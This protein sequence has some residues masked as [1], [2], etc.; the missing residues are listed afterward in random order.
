M[1]DA[2]ERWDAKYRD[3]KW[4][5]LPPCDPFVLAALAEC[6]DG[7]GRRALDAAAGTGRHALELASRGWRTDAWDLSS[8]GLSRLAGFAEANGLGVATR[9]FDLTHALPDDTFD[10]V[11][12]VN[13]LDRELLPRLGR[14][15]SPGG[16]LVFTTFTTD[17][18]S[19]PSERHCLAGGEL[20]AGIDGLVTQRYEEQGGRAGLVA[21][22]PHS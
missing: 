20:A 14:R 3:A 17:R 22:R 1:T 16:R 2:I 6:G 8:V 11:V 5:A 19:G 13:Y 18:D 9:E 4:E 10:L 12:V 15:L 7:A 21:A